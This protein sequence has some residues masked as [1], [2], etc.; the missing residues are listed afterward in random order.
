MLADADRWNIYADRH[1]QKALRL[2]IVTAGQLDAAHLATERAIRG[3]L[4]T[5][6]LDTDPDLRAWHERLDHAERQAAL[7]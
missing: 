2:G 5:Y 7:P 4:D 1:N 6:C 3:I